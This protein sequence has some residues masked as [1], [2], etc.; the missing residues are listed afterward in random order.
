MRYEIESALT[1]N[2]R[3]DTLTVKNSPRGNGSNITKTIFVTG[4][5]RT[6][7][8]TLQATLDDGTT[9]FNVT[10]ASGNVEFT[11]DSGVNIDIASDAENPVKV[12][13][14]L[15]GATSPNLIL[16]VFDAA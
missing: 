4:D 1:A 3:S 6:G 5:F 14:N 7:T 15:T 2:G 11:E 9:W 16:T 8:A 10:N 12:A 13:I